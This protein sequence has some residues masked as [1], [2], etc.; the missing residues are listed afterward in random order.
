MSQLIVKSPKH[1][2]NHGVNIEKFYKK[3]FYAFSTFFFSILF[4]V[5]L[6][7]L[8]LRPAKPEFYLKQADV[9]QF[10]LS[11]SSHLLNSSIQITLVSRNPNTKVGIYYD[12]LKACAS[13]KSQQ[14]TIGAP[15]P[16]FY[17]GH[18]DRNLLIASLIGTGLSV[19]PSFGY[20]VSRDQVVGKV[21]LQLKVNGRLR[22]KVGTWVSGQY[23]LSVVCVTMMS[24]D[25]NTGAGPLSLKQ[26]SQCSTSV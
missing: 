7:W 9:Y 20:E 11:G 4:T 3:L 21:V 6:I 14:I 19:S 22:W 17:Q 2:A 25:S 1:C 15:I 13:Y 24:F 16:P 10:N 18:E 5:F 12:Q 8:I 23:R 26:G